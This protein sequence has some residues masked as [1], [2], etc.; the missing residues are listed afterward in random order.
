LKGHKVDDEAGG[1]VLKTPEKQE[2]IVAQMRA[3]LVAGSDPPSLMLVWSFIELARRPEIQT[4]VREEINAALGAE[5]DWNHLQSSCPLLDGVISEVL[6]LHISFGEAP[7]V[8][9]E[10]DVI[11]LKEPT[12]DAS[13]RLVDR[14]H[15]PK[16]TRIIIPNHYLNYSPSIWGP[17]GAVFNP[18]RWIVDPLSKSGDSREGLPPGARLW[19]FGE[20]PRMCVGKAFAMTLIKIVLAVLLRDFVFELPQGPET[21]IDVHYS[22]VARPK[23]KGLNGAKFPLL[24]S[25]AR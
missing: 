22:I 8:A 15:I 17:D 24:V 19:T 16:G 5:L 12:L 9:S 6:R 7:R 18:D 1:S 25:R 13:G 3:I 2:E 10:D 21:P 11:Q 23:I 20:G 14:I 4:R